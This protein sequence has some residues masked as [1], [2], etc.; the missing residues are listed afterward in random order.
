MKKQK[1]WAKATKI[2]REASGFFIAETDSEKLR[3]GILG[4]ACVDTPHQHERIREVAGLPD[5]QFETQVG[6]LFSELHPEE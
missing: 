2:L 5:G 6:Q 4:G 3:V 1:R